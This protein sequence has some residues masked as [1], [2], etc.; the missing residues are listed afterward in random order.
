MKNFILPGVSEKFN[1]NK[2]LVLLYE[3][4]PDLFIDNFNI[5]CVYGNFGRCIWNGGRIT[6]QQ[7]I[8]SDL[9]EDI[10]EKRDFFNKRNIPIRLTM[11]NPVI[12]PIHYTDR[13]SNLIME[14]LDNG[15]NEVL[16]NNDDFEQF[17][18]AKYPSYKLCSST[19]K[20]ITNQKEVLKELSSERYIQVCLDYNLN[21]NRMLLE[22]ILK[23]DLQ[24]KTEFL[25][26][27]ICP[28]GCPSRKEHYKLNGISALHLYK[29][30]T[31]PECTI[32]SHCFSEQAFH[33]TNNLSPQEI[34][35]YET[36]GFSNFKLEG[37]TLED[38]ELLML[39]IHYFIKEAKK[40]QATFELF[41]IYQSII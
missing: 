33:Y 7:P 40:E 41:N 13:Y 26:N 5:R 38:T 23:K 3:N 35:E 6:T 28:P 15:Q 16:T 19:T 8:Y 9:Y 27:A 18:H 4:S 1:C 37:R 2:A 30:F 21:H 11:T 10:I 25:C 34:N 29:I 39:Y 12:E 36:R 22:E 32:S 14:L 31:V 24:D 20:C 17:L